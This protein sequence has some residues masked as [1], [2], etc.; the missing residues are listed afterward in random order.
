MELTKCP[1]CENQIKDQANYCPN[2]GY[3]IVSKVV[4]WNIEPS[5][6]QESKKNEFL[7]SLINTN[8]SAKQMPIEKK[9]KTKRDLNWGWVTLIVIAFIFLLIILNSTDNKGIDDTRSSKDN[10]AQSMYKRYDYKTEIKYSKVS[11]NVRSEP[12]SKSK[13]LKSLKPNDKVI[14]HDTIVDGYTMVLN[15]DYTNYGWTTVKYLQSSPL[16]KIQ[17]EQL[18]QKNKLLKYEIYAKE[19]LSFA[20]KKR[21]VNRVELNEEIVPVDSDLKEVAMEIWSDGNKNWDEFTVFFYLSD[22]NKDGSAYGI[23]EFNKSG[24]ESFKSGLGREVGST[25]E[26]PIK[27]DM[28]QNDIKPIPKPIITPPEVE[29]FQYVEKELKG[30]KYMEVISISVSER[31][32]IFYDIVKY[33]DD[34]GDDD[35]AR[36]VIAKR[37]N[38]P[39]QA[40]V[41]IAMEG[42]LKN[43]PMPKI[44]K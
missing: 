44:S 36:T 18:T 40:V 10:N 17:I 39:T 6:N 29:D 30:W 43:W 38:I 11:L 7:K 37:Y 13:I 23:A 21:M 34:T 8:M 5:N 12:N 14:I 28:E 2:C 20:G 42:A 16:S 1:K 31:Q 25:V 4:E 3:P 22:M 15:A 32:K 26:N 35:G 27:S 19:D 41:G 24:L 33:Q 9:F